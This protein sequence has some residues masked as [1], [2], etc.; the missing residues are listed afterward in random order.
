MNS[1]AQVSAQKQ[2]IQ[3]HPEGAIEAHSRCACPE[4]RPEGQ[5]AGL[6]GV[7]RPVGRPPGARL[8]A[9]SSSLAALQK[10]RFPWELSPDAAVLV[11]VAAAQGSPRDHLGLRAESLVFLGF[12]G[13]L[14]T[15]ETV[16]DWLATTFRELDRQRIDKP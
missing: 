10:P 12:A 13:P 9:S 16:L 7:C 6:T 15:G 4:G 1:P 11:S 14:T 2:Q 5:A 8:A 3:G